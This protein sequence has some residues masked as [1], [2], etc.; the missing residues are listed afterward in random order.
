MAK[1]E[2]TTA[3]D[4]RKGT[5][6]V[7]PGYDPFDNYAKNHSRKDWLGSLLKFNKGEWLAGQ[8]NAEIES[9]TQMVAMIG[10]LLVGW[11]KWEDNKKVDQQMGLLKDNFHVERSDLG[12]T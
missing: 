3:S 10:D 9:G 11:V 2:V 6:L 12:D 7:Q 4:S 1:N 8:D 5:A